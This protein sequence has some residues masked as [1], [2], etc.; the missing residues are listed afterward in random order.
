MPLL[1]SDPNPEYFPP[2]F[3]SLSL[4]VL[5]LSEYL[6]LPLLV[7]RAVCCGSTL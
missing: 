4:L 6:S 5:L 1:L 7:S 3:D 2:Y